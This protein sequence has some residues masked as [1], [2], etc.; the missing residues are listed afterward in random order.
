MINKKILCKILCRNIQIKDNHLVINRKS[1]KNKLVKNIIKEYKKNATEK[2]ITSPYSY[3]ILQEGFKNKGLCDREQLFALYAL[4]EILKSYYL[5]LLYFDIRNYIYFFNAVDTESLE[6][7]II[8]WNNKFN[9]DDF[10]ITE[11]ASV[12][13]EN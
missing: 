9:I 7:E 13:L 4:S 8:L 12:L 6:A 5:A 3:G 11:Y 10:Y 1:I 2:C